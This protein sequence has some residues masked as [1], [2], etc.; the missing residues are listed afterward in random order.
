MVEAPLPW[1]YLVEVLGRLNGVS[2]L[3]DLGTGGGEVLSQIA[4]FLRGLSR[5]RSTLRT[6][7]SQPGGSIPWGPGSKP[8]MENYAA[9]GAPRLCAPDPPDRGRNRRFSSYFP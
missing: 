9:R 7:R 4:P 1:D 8:R 2:A 6:R 5:R 3:L